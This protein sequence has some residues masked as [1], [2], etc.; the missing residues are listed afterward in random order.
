MTT[1][2]SARP[3]RSRRH[4]ERVT[5]RA[6]VEPHDAGVA[7]IVHVHLHQLDPAGE[8][9]V[10]LRGPA[11]FGGARRSP[12]RRPWR[13]RWV[14][15]SPD[16]FARR[17]R[18]GRG[19]GPRGGWWTLSPGAH[20]CCTGRGG[21]VDAWKDRHEPP[22]AR[23]HR[24]RA[25]IG[26]SRGSRACARSRS[27]RWLRRC[28]PAHAPLRQV[29]SPQDGRPWRRVR[30][31][32]AG[33]N[34]GGPGCRHTVEHDERQHADGHADAEPQ[35]GLAQFTSSPPDTCAQWS[36]GS[37][38]HIPSWTVACPELSRATRRSW[39]QFPAPR[40]PH[41]AG[42]RRSV[43][44]VTRRRRN[45]YRRGGRTGGHVG[46]PDRVVA[47]VVDRGVQQ[48]E[49]LSGDHQVCDRAYCS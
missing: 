49:R 27:R 47:E 29:L 35:Q 10:A 21:W 25:D 26:S 1:R 46:D 31:V 44:S 40:P 33:V 43:R 30:T 17:G 16:P 42:S 39:E 19:T 22:V 32:A 45:R 11:P 28:Q 3:R 23:R 4:H 7:D 24:R 20:G 37:L 18:C 2:W 15:A 6:R 13:G 41:A 8:R 5:C 36:T 14:A 38:L 34:A 9:V 48:N 12:G